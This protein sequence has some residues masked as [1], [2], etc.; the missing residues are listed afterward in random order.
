MKFSFV[1]LPS[2]L[3]LVL[4]LRFQRS[5]NVIDLIVG[6]EIPTNNFGMKIATGKMSTPLCFFCK[7]TPNCVYIEL[8]RSLSKLT[9][10]SGQCKFDLGSMSKMSKLCQ[11]A[12]HLTRIDGTMVF[13]LL[14]G[15]AGPI[16]NFHKPYRCSIL[17][18]W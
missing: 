14:C 17:L 7:C 12:Y 2:N 6:L 16:G 4:R 18:F 5:V 10:N 3:T 15:Y 9:S 1:K 8:K 11:D 13:I